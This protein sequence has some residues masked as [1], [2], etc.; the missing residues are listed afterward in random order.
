M[1][2]KNKFKR[3]E[4][5]PNWMSNIHSTGYRLEQGNISPNFQMIIHQNKKNLNNA[6][7][8]FLFSDCMQTTRFTVFVLFV[9]VCFLFL[10]LFVCLFCC[11]CC[12]F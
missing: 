3:T 4:I 9:F 10:F 5:F 2:N 6:V 8:A 7:R 11:C 1:Q 12:C